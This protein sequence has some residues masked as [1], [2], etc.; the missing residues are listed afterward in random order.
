[1][2]LTRAVGW[3]RL[4]VV[5]ALIAALTSVA[6]LA[7]VGAGPSV[8]RKFVKRLVTKR[9]NV[10]QNQ[11]SQSI[12]ETRMNAVSIQLVGPRQVVGAATDTTV[13]TLPIPDAGNYVVSTKLWW[14]VT[15]DTSTGTGGEIDCDLLAGSAFDTSRESGVTD[16][17]YGTLN[18]QLAQTFPGAG[19]VTLR[20]RDEFQGGNPVQVHNVVMSAVEMFALSSTRLDR[21]T[22]ADPAP[23][24]VR[25]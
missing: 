18:L 6:L 17:D 19:D 11:L 23:V 10:V 14:S 20:C 2:K 5:L 24:G 12:R 13:A 21:S 15:N 7:P 25:P 8:T 16:F 3:L 22:P 9:V 1:M 4:G